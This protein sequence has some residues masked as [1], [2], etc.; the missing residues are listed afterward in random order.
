MK[1]R[2]Q[3]VSQH[4]ENVSRKALEDHPDLIRRYVRQRQGVYALYRKGKLYYVGLAT[5][6]K[7]RLAQH[8][9]DKHGQS[10]D[11]FSIYFT[12]GDYHL[13]ELEALILRVVKPAGNRQKGAFVRSEDI[14]RQFRQ[15][16]KQAVLDGVDELFR[17]L[18]Q[19]PIE[20]GHNAHEESKPVLARFKQAPKRLRGFYKGKT[21]LA[22]VR[23]DGKIR[24]AGRIF[25]SPSL[26]AMAVCKRKSCNG[27]TFW[28][29]ERAPGDWVLL[30][31]LRQ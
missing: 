4:I 26:A 30:D 31:Y 12:I 8:L 19:S 10:W 2:A 27:W 16:I 17:G 3:L 23:R 14:T 28:Q 21:F 15:D 11:Q 13:R 7:N 20:T 29:Y 18:I 1:K 22:S 24:A 6:L 9:K 5:N 25:N